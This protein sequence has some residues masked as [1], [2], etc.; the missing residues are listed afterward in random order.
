MALFQSIQIKQRNPIPSLDEANEPLYIFGEFVVP[1]GGLA[2]N[3]VIEMGGLTED[4]RIIDAVI[5]NTAMGVGA[6]FDMGV[7]LG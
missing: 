1:T 2:I 3:D 5:H 4:M 6:T 7:N